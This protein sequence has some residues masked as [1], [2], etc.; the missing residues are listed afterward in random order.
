MSTRVLLPC[1]LYVLV[2]CGGNCNW[3][4]PFPQKPLPPAVPP[5]WGF[6]DLHAHPGAHLA[7]G[8]ENGRWGILFGQPGKDLPSAA[9]SWSTDLAACPADVH[10]AGPD[11]DP[12][13][14]ATRAAVITGLGQVG[15]HPHG[16]NGE[17]TY[18]AW[19]HAM[20]TLHQQMHVTMLRRAY[21]GGLRLLFAS[22]TD[23]QTLSMVW[24]VGFNVFGNNPQA[25]PTFDRTRVFEQLQWLREYAQANADWM[26]IA[27][28]PARA[29]EIIGAGKLA[30][31][32]SL[33]MDQLRA[34]DVLE[35]Q[36]LG[37]RHVIPI[38]LVDNS[39]GGAAVY[40]D[41]FNTSNRFL[42]GG[43]FQ[44]EASSTTLFRLGWPAELA[45][46]EWLGKVATH[47]IPRADFCALGYEPCADLPLGTAVGFEWG[48]RNA[49]GL[50][51]PEFLKSLMRAGMMVDV[52]HM[53][54]KSTE[55][56]LALGE[57]LHYP[58]MNSHTALRD[59]LP[60][61]AVGGPKHKKR[62][63]SE[64]DMT[65][66]HARRLAAIG[67]VMGL[68]TEGRLEP[69][70]LLP[71][72]GNPLA[73][74]GPSNPEVKLPIAFGGALPLVAPIERLEVTIDTG[75]GR[76]PGSGQDAFADVELAN[77]AST[78]PA[79]LNG[80]A[81]WAPYSTH[82]AVI[83]LPQGTKLSDLVAF[84]IRTSLVT[85]GL[86]VPWYLSVLSVR[87]VG[88]LGATEALRR[89]GEPWH[90]FTEQDHE[91]RVPFDWSAPLSP[92][93]R[94]AALRF[95]C[96]TGND[97]LRGDGDNVSA[98]AHL[99]STLSR[100]QML[101]GRQGWA[102]GST[103][104][105]SYALPKGTTLGD[106]EA[107]ELLT[108]FGGG[109]SG[110]NW[111]LDDLVV[112][113]DDGQGNWT[114]LAHRE[115]SPYVRFTGEQKRKIVWTGPAEGEDPSLDASYL[116]LSFTTGAEPLDASN[117]ATATV[118][119]SDSST[120]ALNVNLWGTL[121]PFTTYQ[122][123]LRLPDGTRRGDLQLLTVGVNKNVG[124]VWQL[125]QVKVDL[126][127]DP[128]A[129]F[130]ADYTDAL[131]LM[132]G[133]AVALG[134]DFNGFATQIPYSRVDFDYPLHS[135][136]LHAPAPLKA[137]IPL[138]PR[139]TLGGRVFDP[140]DD[141]LAHY[142]LL[143]ELIESLDQLPGGP[144]VVDKLYGSAEAV[145]EMWEAC[146]KAAPTVP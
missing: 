72:A 8:A 64:R 106:I 120:H 81:Y 25:D 26:E 21:D 44:V 6:A 31:V 24:H 14:H 102:G 32:L 83:P 9:A 133:R 140:R 34:T 84:T 114:V 60:L 117:T 50:G 68:G 101:N 19:P 143:P 123:I 49:R 98:I 128:V 29:R 96:R 3:P 145:L 53:S 66:D 56:A 59:T 126:I 37:V 71:M 115:G 97:D 43:F 10:V 92:S 79:P 38:H 4:D 141:G 124:D 87:A 69:V 61:D 65:Y 138:I 54:E 80:G 142:G 125:E 67:G 63:T 40:Q 74:L 104:S 137:Q 33:E 36:K 94:V 78:V 46:G 110:D 52:A 12:A 39:F 77:Q 103:H 112:E 5:V 47:L 107:I 127:G 11:L 57:E 45:G 82:T 88:P 55:D 85:S 70:S 134:T 130:L 42:T 22:V 132:K 146:E 108:S 122:R 139:A 20:S 99:R 28:S 86:S 144:A 119:L 135:P 35:F 105:F 41:L 113:A 91:V 93:Q 48:H 73:L 62:V 75:E 23:N 13:R 30:V 2:S 89:E 51:P 1:V 131:G 116:R 16:A 129:S 136:N 95:T 15:K 17:S 90:R 18:Q 7:F 111:N 118:S 109:I 76:L 27:D 121:E 58:L 100:A